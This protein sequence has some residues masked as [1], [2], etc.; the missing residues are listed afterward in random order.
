MSEKPSMEKRMSQG[1][2]QG[3]TRRDF[4][5]GAECGHCGGPDRRAGGVRQEGRR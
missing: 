2:D 1:I 3:L 4:V 5:Q